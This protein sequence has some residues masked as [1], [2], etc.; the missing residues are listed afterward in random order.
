MN[1]EK[2]RNTL[3]LAAYERRKQEFIEKYSHTPDQDYINWYGLKMAQYID[4]RQTY[5]VIHHNKKDWW[6]YQEEDSEWLNNQ[7][8]NFLKRQ[9]F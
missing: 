7:E 4:A 2:Y 6:E 1:H 9:A 5:D 8:I 3:R